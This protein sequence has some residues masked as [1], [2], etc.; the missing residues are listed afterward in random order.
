M[1]LMLPA[2]MPAFKATRVPPIAA[3]R[4]GATIAPGR[5]ARFRTPIAAF[6]TVLGFARVVWGVFGPDLDTT[7]ILLF[8]ILGMVLVFIGVAML[9]APLI[10]GLTGALGW[11]G[12]RL[13]GADRASAR[14]H[15]RR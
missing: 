3:V 2:M 1:V 14:A 6:I 4:E 12:A 13:G 8:M 5:F 9:S 11:P 15:A 7:Q 10:P